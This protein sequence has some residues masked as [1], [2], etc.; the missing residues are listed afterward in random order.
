[1]HKDSVELAKRSQK[2]LCSPD[3]DL[4]PSRWGQHEAPLRR[5]DLPRMLNAAIQTARSFTA[6]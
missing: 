6:G 5:Q 2:L 4:I 1:L 3:V